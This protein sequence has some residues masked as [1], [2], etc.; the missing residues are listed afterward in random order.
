MYKTFN[1]LRKIYNWNWKLLL[2]V[3]IINSLYY[4]IHTQ[5]YN[6]NFQFKNYLYSSEVQFKIVVC[7]EFHSYIH[8]LIVFYYVSFYFWKVKWTQIKFG[9]HAKNISINF[10]MVVDDCKEIYSFCGVFTR[11]LTTKFYQLSLL[12][13]TLAFQKS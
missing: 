6:F 3:D 13:D 2:V 9:M 7:Y 1:V 5:N 12:E 10:K 4:L 11:F 8:V